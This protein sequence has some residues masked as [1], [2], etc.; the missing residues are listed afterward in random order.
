M[1]NSA[2][3]GNSIF[4]G[5]SVLIFLSLFTACGTNNPANRNA[6][7]VNKDGNTAQI[8][9]APPINASDDAEALGKL[10]KLPIAPDEVFW[11]V[12][13]DAQNSA[14]QRDR[15]NSP[16][17]LTTETPAKDENSRRL[18][19]VLKY[20]DENTE[21][22]IQS[23]SQHGAGVDTTF[24]PEEWFPAELIA[25][26]DTSGDQSLKGKLFQPRDFLQAPYTVGKLIKVDQP[27]YFVL[28]LTTF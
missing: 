20:S 18:V 6:A 4:A 21:Q 28:E 12:E 10:I 23:A 14:A 7:N 8:A 25:E 1:K 17:P 9:E 5:L 2:H 19:A 24:V 3:N 11:Y 15:G 22:V 13:T 26:S 16:R 27:G